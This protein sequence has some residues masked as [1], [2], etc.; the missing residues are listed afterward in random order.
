MLWYI[1]RDGKEHGP[2]SQTEFAEFLKRGH[3]LPSDYVWHEGLDD[4]YLGI[5]LLSGRHHVAERQAVAP[6]AD[7]NVAGPTKRSLTG[8]RLVLGLFARWVRRPHRDRLASRRNQTSWK[9]IRVD[10]LTLGPSKPTGRVGG[11]TGKVR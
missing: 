2:I 9:V 11:L 1:A 7:T 8:L 6:R 3:L 4:W 5:D 10:A